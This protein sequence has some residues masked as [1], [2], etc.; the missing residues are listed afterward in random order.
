MEITIIITA[1]LVAVVSSIIGCFLVL[2]KMAMVGDAISH[3]VLP[4]IVIAF[5]LGGKM[6]SWYLLVGAAAF[7]L[8]TTFL[9][10]FF[11]KKGNVQQDAAIGVVFTSL[12]AVGI[13]LISLYTRDV[14]LDQDCVLYGEL[15]HVAFEGGINILGMMVP[16]TILRL[17]I[18]LLSVIAMVIIGFRGLF[19]TTFDPAYATTIGV[20]V[21]L[22]HYVLMSAV[23]ISTVLSFNSVGAILVVGFLITP[24]ATAYLISH[25][26][27]PM[28]LWAVLFGIIASIS[29]Y[30]LAGWV[31][32]AT[33]AA[34]AT[35]LGVQFLVVFIYK[36]IKDKIVPLKLHVG[37]SQHKK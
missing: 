32:G 30:Y 37:D 5:M 17:S 33:S 26:I 34:M 3:A 1:I 35:M 10:E 13:I 2:R 6:G 9:I 7:G 18:L 22:W 12:F 36:L 8:I 28:I 14:D 27:V 24:A 4:G 19:L 16:E 20:S 31:N 29:G 25:K 11:N 21:L 23:S 15:D